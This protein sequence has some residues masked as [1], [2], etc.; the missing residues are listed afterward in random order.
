MTRIHLPTDYRQTFSTKCS[1]GSF[2]FL[3]ASLLRIR[4]ILYHLIFKPQG[5]AFIFECLECTS[6]W[7]Q[8][9]VR[10]D[11]KTETRPEY[12]KSSLFPFGS[13][14]I[15]DFNQKIANPFLNSFQGIRRKIHLDEI[16]T[17]LF[18]QMKVTIE[19]Q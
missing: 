6:L 3:R 18:K 15:K 2:L 16:S 14:N 7:M 8:R 5:S 17:P 12:R 10:R 4:P 11:L 9:A 13:T 1:F 19:L